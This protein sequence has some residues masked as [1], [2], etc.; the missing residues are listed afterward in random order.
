MSESWVPSAR[1][2]ERQRFRVAQRRRSFAVVLASTVVVA[3]VAV[4]VVVCSPGI[5]SRDP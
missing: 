1:A 4:V 3:A 2:L 5:R